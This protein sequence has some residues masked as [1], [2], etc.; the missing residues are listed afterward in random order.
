MSEHKM[1]TTP[2]LSITELQFDPKSVPLNKPFDIKISI[3]ANI[4]SQKEK[5]DVL[6]YFTITQDNE[7]LYTSDTTTLKA[8]NGLSETFNAHMDAV[9]VSGEYMLKAFIKYGKLSN[10]KSVKLTI[11]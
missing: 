10:E 4:P 11:K 3:E 2:S 6:F 1:T 7:V 9:P 8:T 5:L